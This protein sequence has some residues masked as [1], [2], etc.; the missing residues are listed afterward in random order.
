MRVL[1]KRFFGRKQQP[2]YSIWTAPPKHKFVAKWSPVVY[3]EKDLGYPEGEFAEAWTRF[4]EARK[5]LE[6]FR[7]KFNEKFGAEE[8][9]GHYSVSSDVKVRVRGKTFT[10]YHSES[11]LH[12]W[13]LHKSSCP[14]RDNSNHANG[15]EYIF[16]GRITEFREEMANFLLENSPYLKKVLSEQQGLWWEY[17]KRKS[18]GWLNGTEKTIFERPE[19]LSEELYEHLLRTDAM[20]FELLVPKFHQHIQTS[21]MRFGVEVRRERGRERYVPDAHDRL[22]QL[23]EQVVDELNE[24]REE[25]PHFDDNVCVLC[26]LKIK[27]DLYRNLQYNLPNEVCAWCVKL[28]ESNPIEVVS[29]GK[30]PEML[31]AEAIEGFQLAVKTFNYPHWRGP[32]LSTKAVVNLELRTTTPLRFRQLAAVIAGTP[33]DLVGY[34]S[35]LHFL[36]AAGYESL[37]NNPKSRGKKSIS[38]CNHICLSLG[39][40]DICEYLAASGFEHTREPS[41]GPL[42]GAIGVTEFGGMRG[43]FLVGKTVIEFAGLAG[44]A[45]YDAKMGL[46]KNLCKE[47][48]IDLIVVLPSDLSRLSALLSEEKLSKGETK[49]L[50]G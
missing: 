33:K 22:M 12:D 11:E 21:A 27:P 29:A 16:R 36:K 20:I 19:Y 25:C 32:T 6:P 38:S 5:I 42:T 41:Y 8:W 47:Y 10:I 3:E 46:K 14:K 17:L 2:K 34:E 9:K 44:N 15:W 23:I 24:H 49:L 4:T 7:A 48:G 28:L 1:L 13:L 18:Q 39:E 40:R 30:A 26:D 35:T 31:K 50:E 37:A 43:D 45:E